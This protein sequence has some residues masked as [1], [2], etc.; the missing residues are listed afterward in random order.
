MARPRFDNQLI[1]A[2]A[3]IAAIIFAGACT[4][5]VERAD[6]PAP[7]PAAAGAAGE[8]CPPGWPAVERAWDATSWLPLD[9]GRATVRLLRYAA[10][11]GGDDCAGPPSFASVAASASP[12]LLW[13]KTWPDDFRA[14]AVR[15]GWPDGAVDRCKPPRAE[16]PPRAAPH[17]EAVLADQC[18]ALRAELFYGTPEAAEEL[19]LRDDLAVTPA[20]YSW[21]PAEQLAAC[22]E[23][24][25]EALPL[26]GTPRVCRNAPASLA[27]DLPARLLGS[28]TAG[29]AD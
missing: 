5:P 20:V 24:L 13:E 21:W 16:Q 9:D 6:A 29:A 4:D 19:Q 10:E 18:I 25:V 8:L 7:V 23:A 15:L 2:A 28:V 3:A 11:R 22:K 14:D 26:G 27:R 17:W 1:A 12:R